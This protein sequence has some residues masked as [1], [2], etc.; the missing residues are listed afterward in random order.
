MKRFVSC[1][2]VS[3]LVCT[4]IMMTSIGHAEPLGA[5]SADAV[6]NAAPVI[7]N[8][9]LADASAGIAYKD[10]VIVEDADEGDTLVFSLADSPVWMEISDSGL[11]TGLPGSADVGTAV[12]VTVIAEDAAGAADTLAT[13]IEVAYLNN[14]AVTLIPDTDVSQPGP[15]GE[16]TIPNPGPD[17]YFGFAVYLDSAEE[18]RSFR[19]RLRWDPAY[20][21][22]KSSRSGADIESDDYRFNGVDGTVF[23]AEDNILRRD[24]GSITPIVETDEDG[25]FAEVYA[26]L[27]GDAVAGEGGLVYLAVFKTT[28]TV[29][30]TDMFEVIAQV[31]VLDDGGKEYTP[32][33][34]VFTVGHPLAPPLDVVLADIP[35]D[36]GH[37]RSLSWT[38]SSSEE[39]GAVTHYYIYRSRAPELTDPVSIG[40]FTEIDSLLAAE[41]TRTVLIDSVAA[42]ITE[43]IDESVPL[44]GA[45]YFY[46]LQAVGP[47]GA[48]EKISAGNPV[49]VEGG[50]SPE[51]FRLEQPFPNPFNPATTIGYTL[52]AESPVVLTVHNAAGQRVETLVDDIRPAGAHAVVWNAPHL[53]SGVYYCVMESGGARLTRKMLLVK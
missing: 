46:W 1:A 28:T 42:G 45:E 35:D 5:S 7:L 10:S 23:A 29:S 37:A 32:E 49:L 51:A 33:E 26:R 36:H 15:H 53:S 2:A 40:A 11:I 25:E 18:L 27:G 6:E 41:E 13:V 9:T 3:F 48:S 30:E 24:N 14:A 19:I 21:V 38:L 20:A 17:E 47:D 12:P 50:S 4:C 52:S 43:Y 34:L 16:D 22:F 31:S 44:G 8:E 39:T